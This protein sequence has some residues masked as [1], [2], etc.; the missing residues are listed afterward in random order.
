MEGLDSAVPAIL[1]HGF[2]AIG[3]QILPPLRNVGLRARII[4]G[5]KRRLIGLG[6]FPLLKRIFRVGGFDHSTTPNDATRAG[7]S[8]GGQSHR[9]QSRKVRSRRPRS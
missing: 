9:R 1:D 6:R 5:P 2:D 7:T 4:V 3:R 8:S